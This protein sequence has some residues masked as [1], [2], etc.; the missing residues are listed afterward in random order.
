MSARD[1]L[2]AAA[3]ATARE[4]PLDAVTAA[5]ICRHAQLDEAA[6][7]GNFG[8]LT[9]YLVAVQQA[10]MNRMRDRIVAV[11]AGVPPGLRRIQLAT[12][13]YLGGCLAERALRSWLLGA[14]MRPPVLSALHRHYRVYYVI[15]GA[16]LEKLRW[17]DSAAAAR[18]YLAM[19]NAAA[20]VE[21]RLGP[22]PQLREALWHFLSHGGGPAAA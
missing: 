21:H 5:D 8:D 22:Q 11:T 12:E 6:F 19:I 3:S 1:A 14:R 17:P 4:H 18:L 20:V 2:I 10:F 16:E 13:S 15:L 7:T 9:G